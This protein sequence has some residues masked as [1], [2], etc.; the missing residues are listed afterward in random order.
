VEPSW[1][2]WFRPV[3]LALR[4]WWQEDS[5]LEASLGYNIVRPYLKKI[6]GWEHIA[7]W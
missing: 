6:K 4:R 5:E 3:I 1:A 2:W 7:K